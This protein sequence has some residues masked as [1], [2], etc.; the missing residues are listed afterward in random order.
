VAENG[1]AVALDVIIEP[2]AMANTGQN[3][4][5]RRLADLELGRGGDAGA[6]DGARASIALATRLRFAAGSV[7][8]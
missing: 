4:G 8:R 1:R 5:E 2:N 3:I 7:A 6:A